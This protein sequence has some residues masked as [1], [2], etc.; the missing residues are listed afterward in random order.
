MPAFLD[1][2]FLNNQVLGASLGTWLI[3]L[4][5]WAFI[6]AA[7]VSLR[8]LLLRRLDAASKSR[9]LPG[10]EEILRVALRSTLTSVLV[11]VALY[12][13]LVVTGIAEDVTRAVG[14]ILV[15]VLLFQVARWGTGLIKL[16]VDRY[17]ETHPQTPV[18]AT[19]AVGIF[20][21]LALYSLV[22]LL[23]LENL[24]VDITALV[25]G[26]GIGGVA[27]ALAVQNILG[28]ILAYVSIIFDEPFV[29][30]D[31]LVVGNQMGTVEKIGIKT[32]RVRSL[33]GELIIFANSDLLGSRIHNYE[34]M[35]ERRILFT[36]GVLY[37]TPHEKLAKIPSMMREIIEAQDKTRF[38]RAHF[39]GFGES[40]LTF[41]MVYHVQS[42]DYGVYMDIQQAINLGIS[43][44]F[45][46]EDIGFPYPTRTLYMSTPPPPGNGVKEP[47]KR[48]P[49]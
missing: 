35:R 41:E 14:H 2:G 43:K 33:S 49:L 45:A 38:D 3:A 13:A 32:T 5:V 27:V 19:R 42:P 22:V 11:V 23:T 46:E 17:G 16:A 34:Q 26:L 36:I 31:Y 28:D 10:V 9:G 47:P 6:A 29:T 1:H 21:R 39:R 20:A 44:R 48:M 7:L 12:A 18:S 25:T 4:A 40:D 8:I 37:E 15:V 24:G 30:G